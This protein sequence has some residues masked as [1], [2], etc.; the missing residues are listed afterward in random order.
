MLFSSSDDEVGALQRRD[1]R[2][3]RSER[4]ERSNQTEPEWWN[5]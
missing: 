1:P 4:S 3:E 2:S 5:W